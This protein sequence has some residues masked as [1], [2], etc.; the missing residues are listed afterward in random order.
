MGYA[1]NERMFREGTSLE[2]H[3][4]THQTR[5]SGAG[6]QPSRA[7]NADQDMINTEFLVHC[8]GLLCWGWEW[9]SWGKG[10]SR[11]VGC[12]R[13]QQASGAVTWPHR[14]REMP[15]EPPVSR[16]HAGEHCGLCM[17]ADRRDGDKQL[18]S[19]APGEQITG[20]H[21]PYGS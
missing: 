6:L 13:H 20:S 5:G 11:T 3:A 12:G 2:L 17:C 15:R 1:W 7:Q 21:L 9:L 10:W 16:G 19:L 8:C 14:R 4:Q 18:M